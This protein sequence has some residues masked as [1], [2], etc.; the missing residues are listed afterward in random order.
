VL[1][2]RLNRLLVEADV[3]DEVSMR[4]V[5]SDEMARCE[6]FL[7]SPSL[8]IDGHDVEPGAEQRTVFGLTCRLFATVDGLRGMP[9]NEWVLDALTRA[10]ARTTG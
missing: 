10:R 6:R 7:G 3:D 9:T 4:R 2:E 1:L 8:R 5:E